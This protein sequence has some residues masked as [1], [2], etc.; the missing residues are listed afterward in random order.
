M[1]STVIRHQSTLLFRERRVALFTCLILAMIAVAFGNGFARQVRWSS[2]RAAAEKVDAESWNAQGVVNPHYAAHFGRHA[3][4]PVSDLAVLD[5]GVLDYVGTLVRLEAHRQHPAGG[6]P[7]DADTALASFT[8]FTVAG[9]LTTFVPLVLVLAG[10]STFS[11][12][13]ARQLLR[14]ELAS[15]ISPATLL[16]GRTLALC[17]GVL[18]ILLLVGGVAAT[19]LLRSDAPALGF[20]RLV[21]ILAGCGVYLVTMVFLI[22]GVSAYCRSARLALTSLLALWLVG[23]LLVPRLA[24][25]IAANQYP[26]PSL[27]ELNENAADAFAISLD[28][29]SPKETRSERVRA[30]ALEK[31]GVKKVEDLPVNLSGF[32]MEYSETLSTQAYRRH[33]AEVQSLYAKQRGLQ[34][35]FSIFSPMIA[36]KAWSAAWAETDVAAHQRFLSAAEDYRY[37]LVQKLNRDYRDHPPKVGSDNYETDVG[38]LTATLGNFAPSAVRNAELWQLAWPSGAVLVLWSLTATAFASVAVR[39]LGR[40]L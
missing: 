30:L 37:E 31:Y 14:Q 34:Q 9:A 13:S 22:M 3:F 7:T 17:G 1:L 26:V 5:P 15:G 40:R 35:V 23:S 39:Q 18:I 28:A 25:M 21:L 27:P 36:I 19:I 20:Q 38:A 6:S 11:G 10:F 29:G 2:D 16:W 24:P 32:T 33:F 4:K 8:P 12:E